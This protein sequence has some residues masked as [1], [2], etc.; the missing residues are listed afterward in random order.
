MRHLPVAADAWLA[1]SISG[2]QVS[3]LGASRSTEPLTKAMERDEPE[4]VQVAEE[5]PFLRFQHRLAYWRQANDPDSEDQ[6]LNRQH[7]DRSLHLSPTFQG[8][9]VLNGTF[10]PIGGT[11]LHATLTSIERELFQTDWAETNQQLGRDPL[12]TELPRSP[13]QRR[14]DALVEMATRARVAPADGRRPEPLFNVLLGLPQFEQ[15]CEL[16]NGTVLTPTSLLPWLTTAWIERA[17]FQPPS[18]V[19][20]VSAQRRLFTGADRRAIELRDRECF[21]PTCDQPIEQIDHIQPFAWNGPTTQDNGR[22]ACAFHNR[23]RHHREDE[24]P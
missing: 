13:A 4:L 16:F 10:D 19:I 1:G 15:L 6:R 9:W 21:H 17:V 11:I 14:A 7:D 12:A 24:P 22:G 5:L 8:A 23:A 20:D 3:A 18:R 2:A